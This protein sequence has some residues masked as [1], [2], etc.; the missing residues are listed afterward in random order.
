[1]EERI[2]WVELRDEQRGN[3]YH[4][5]LAAVAYAHFYTGRSQRGTVTDAEVA[6]L[7]V[8]GQMVILDGANAAEFRQHF[9]AHLE[10]QDSPFPAS[11]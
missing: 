7:V 5:D 9:L 11:S 6:R 10:K 3:E 8:A 1:M 2:S 4:L